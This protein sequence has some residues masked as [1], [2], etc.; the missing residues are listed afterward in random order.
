[1]EA[2]IRLQDPEKGLLAPA[3]F[4]PALDHPRL[5][6]PIGR[7][8]LKTALQ[9]GEIWQQHGLSLR[10]AVNISTRHLLDSRFL[11]DLQEALHQHPGLPPEQLEIEITE[12]AP[13]QNLHEAQTVL[14]ACRRLGVHIAL[15]DFGTG[16]ASLTYLQQ[17]PAY[18]VK[19]DQ[20]FVRDMIDDPK[21]LAIV[22][23]VITASRMLGMEV[24]AEGVETPELAMLLAKMGCSH[25]QGY[26]FT[27]P[28]PAEEIPDWIQK[29]HFA[30]PMEKNTSSMDV[31]PPVLEAHILRV[32]G[33]LRALREGRSF[34][35]YVLGENAE[36]YCHLGRWLRGE[37]D[38]MFWQLPQ[39]QDLLARHKRLHLIS[40]TAKSL[41]DDGKRVEALHQGD[42]LEKENDQLVEAI[43]L[44]LADVL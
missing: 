24:V 38:L 13:L 43:R 17:F 6:R 34:P 32:Q 44:T 39:F 3:A 33:V 30:F 15:D 12:S 2:L 16:N 1:M 18:A 29:F 4:F 8:V 25:F 21:D 37:G 22:T 41:L 27:K 7:F 14:E 19:V 23:A 5:A 31:L 9:Q 10:I 40:R 36:E 11:E 42:L 28:I 35:G 26:L 20:S